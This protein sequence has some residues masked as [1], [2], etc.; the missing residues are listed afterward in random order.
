M[1]LHEKTCSVC[2]P[3]LRQL[4]LPVSASPGETSARK[5]GKPE[6]GKRGGATIAK[7]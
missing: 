3:K 7:A 5:V 6:T 4:T 2:N 1:C